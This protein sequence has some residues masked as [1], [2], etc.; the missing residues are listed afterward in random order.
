MKI[1]NMLKFHHL[2]LDFEVVGIN[3]TQESNQ[4]ATFIF[5]PGFGDVELNLHLPLAYGKGGAS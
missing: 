3:Q 4:E 5:C 1:K 2:D